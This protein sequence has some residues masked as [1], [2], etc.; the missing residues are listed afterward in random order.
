MTIKHLWLAA[1]LVSLVGC[2]GSTM[3]VSSDDADTSAS[4][5]AA[6]SNDANSGSS[7]IDVDV[8]LPDPPPVLP[9]THT[10]DV[11]LYFHVRNKGTSPATIKRISISSAAGTYELERWSRKYNE[12]IAPGATGKLNFVAR[13]TGVDDNLGLSGPMTVR[14]EI[15]FENADGVQKSAFMRNLGGDFSAGLTRKP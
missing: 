1:A 15:E 10:V 3:G 14:A 12:T 8:T 11:D 4:A 2:A 7:A 9:G 13:A 6:I 5:G